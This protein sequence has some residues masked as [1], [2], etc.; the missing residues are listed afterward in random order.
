MQK[1]LSRNQIHSYG[2]CNFADI[3]GFLPCRNRTRIPS[4]AKSVIVCAFPYYIEDPGPGNVARYAMLPDYH[5][6]VG[7]LLEQCCAALRDTFSG[8]FEGFT[9]ISA[10]PEKQCAVL[11]GLG[12]VGENQLLIHP[13]YGTYCMI[14]EIVT[15]LLFPASEQNTGQCRHCG[16]CVRHCPGG[17]LSQ[18]GLDCTKCLS[19]VT[20]RKGELTQAEANR[21][22]RQ[23]LMWGCDVCQDVCPHNRAIKQTHIKAFLEDIVPEV[24][25]ENLPALIK[26]RAFG[27]KGEKLLLRNLSLLQTQT[28]TQDQ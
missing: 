23:G 15:N 14:G 4:D 8:V 5:T 9:D 6:V 1:I 2:I 11:A 13:E 7:G 25:K 3:S 10:F 24:S 21:I 17:A 16:D 18:T 22:A 28:K 20:Q 19:A 27:Y 26:T 12:F